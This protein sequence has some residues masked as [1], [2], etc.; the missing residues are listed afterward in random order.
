MDGIDMDSDG[1]TQAM[2]LMDDVGSTLTA[3]WSETGNR[4]RGLSGQ[5]GQGELGAAYR[6][7]Y[8]KPAA[9][10]AAA[11]DQHCRQPG[12]L[13]AMGHQCVGMYLTADRSGADGFNGGGPVTEPPSA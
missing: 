13:A 9:D 8:Q 11:I 12:Q 10:T 5:L 3:G 2:Q 6:D 7:G 4:L 1:T